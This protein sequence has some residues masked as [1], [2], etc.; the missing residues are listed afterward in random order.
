MKKALKW[1]ILLIL[2]AVAALILWVYVINGEKE[3]YTAP[4][5]AVK[6]AKPYR[7]NVEESLTFN[8]FVE[9]QAMVPVVPFVSG[10]LES[11]LA[12]AGD[13]VEKDQL[14]AVVDKQPYELQVQ[15][16][17][18]VYLAAKATYERVSNLY[19]TGAVSKQNYDEAKAQYDAY[20]AQ[21]DLANVQ[22]GYT[23]VKAPISGTILMA[24]SSEGSIAT[25]TSPLY[26]IADLSKLKV[27][28]NV[29]EKY[30]DIINDNIENLKVVI[31]RNGATCNASVT[32]VAPYVSPQSKTFAVTLKLTDNISAFRPG[33]FVSVNLVYNKI[34]NALVLDWSVQNSDTSV[35]SYDSSTEK[36]KYE[37]IDITASDAQHFVID[38]KYSNTWFVVDGQG[39]L[40]DGQKVNVL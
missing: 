5:A 9:A 1:I 20:K 25:Q 30:F 19:S 33:M 40:L 23:D 35:Y 10:T 2:A 6:I 15:Q 34:E 24:D 12:K 28:L 14:L 8:G 3:A 21:Y 38:E 31:T 29:P 17:E 7:A 18:A 13:Y 27:N 16:A 39:V 26:V 36:V 22:L 32:S 37:K 11:Y 4:L